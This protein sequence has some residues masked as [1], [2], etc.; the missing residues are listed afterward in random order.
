MRPL[1]KDAIYIAVFWLAV[2]VVMLGVLDAYTL[3]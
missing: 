3:R 1:L 2:F